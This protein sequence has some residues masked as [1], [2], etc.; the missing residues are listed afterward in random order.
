MRK[1]SWILITLVMVSFSGRLV[2]AHHAAA[3]ECAGKSVQKKNNIKQE[4]E[5]LGTM[6]LLPV[7][8][9]METG[10]TNNSN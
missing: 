3:G 1:L 4:E 10:S 6:M 9:N 8:F 7:S 5:S 2:L